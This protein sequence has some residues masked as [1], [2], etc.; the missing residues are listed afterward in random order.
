MKVG[1]LL[2]GGVFKAERRTGVPTSSYGQLVFCV[3]HE[4]GEIIGI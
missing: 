2:T 4:D 3:R 1:N